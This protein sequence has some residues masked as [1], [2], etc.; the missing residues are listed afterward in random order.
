MR[1]HLKLLVVDDDIDNAQSLG[2]L[3][4]MEGHSV[5]VVHN[6]QDAINAYL[7]QSFDLAFMDVMMP[8]KNGVES[9]GE[10]RRLRPEAKVIMM[11]GYSVEELLQQATREGALGVIEKP[12][13]A[14]EVL[15][16]TSHVGEGGMILA[17]PEICPKGLGA[18]IHQT[19]LDHGHQSR[20]IQRRDDL[21]TDGDRNRV[22]VIDIQTP[23][24]DAVSCYCSSSL[25]AEAPT[26]IIVPPQKPD[27]LET[28][29]GWDIEF[30]GILNKPFDPQNLITRLPQ[31]AA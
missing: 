30:T 7:T 2:E 28:S 20:L 14:A 25:R 29:R 13:D 17:M 18:N 24:I 15:R 10:I 3:F 5:C 21:Q 12:L 1:T 19:L 31:L 9:F 4:E 27:M 26:T 22:V 23:I 8:G 11:T 6:G 16:M